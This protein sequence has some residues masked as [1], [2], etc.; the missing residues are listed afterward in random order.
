MFSQLKQTITTLTIH[1]RPNT[2]DERPES[3]DIERETKSN[4]IHVNDQIA[5]NT[6]NQNETKKN[7]KRSSRGLAAS[8]NRQHFDERQ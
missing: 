2:N 6:T 8:N 7:T 4:L 1:T 5:K 3:N